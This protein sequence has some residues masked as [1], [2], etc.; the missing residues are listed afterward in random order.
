MAIQLTM[1][2]AAAAAASEFLLSI[3]LTMLHNL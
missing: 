1:L 2:T 3:Q